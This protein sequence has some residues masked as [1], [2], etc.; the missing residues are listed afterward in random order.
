MSG[1]LVDA[2]VC[3]AA[4]APTRD[5]RIQQYTDYYRWL[6]GMKKEE[7]LDNFWFSDR[8]RQLM[9]GWSSGHLDAWVKTFWSNR[10]TAM[11]V[12]AIN[13]VAVANGGQ[14]RRDRLKRLE[15]IMEDLPGKEPAKLAQAAKA[16]LL[17]TPHGSPGK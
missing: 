9:K 6:D 13:M 3:A 15:K 5:E 1:L 8:E 12:A 2:R 17:K 10:K 11:D 14:D 16:E 4:L 7:V